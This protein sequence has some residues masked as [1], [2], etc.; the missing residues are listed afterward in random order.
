[1]DQAARRHFHH[2]EFDS[3]DLAE[4]KG[5]TTVTVCLPA[6][7]EA[8]TIA[9]IVTTIRHELVDNR[10]LVD[11]ILVVDDRSSDDTAARAA[12][13]GA[14][15]VST[16]DPYGD[17]RVGT[18]KGEAMWR[19]LAGSTGDIVVYCDAD[20]ADFDTRFVIGLIG[21]LLRDETVLFVKGFYERPD[22]H[23]PGT[24]GRTTELVA[25][26]LISLLFPTLTGIVQPLSGEYAARRHV[27]ENVP[28]VQGYGVD[29]GLLVDVEERWGA[30][31][32]AQ[33]DLESRLHRN[34]TLDEL[35]PQSLSI[36]QTGFARAGFPVTRR[37]TLARPGLRPLLCAHVERP[38][39]AELRLRRASA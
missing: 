33:V 5:A 14:T 6:K 1:M 36:M 19:G 20:I 35:S 13:A 22:T 9:G 2:A 32:I 30:E 16:R 24:G 4:A 21:P 8:L 18:G 7:D 28:F 10:G 11:E 39:V 31:A 29:L 12:D 17:L 15:V 26:P 27:L 3:T 25:R 34:R 38:P 23:A 37:A